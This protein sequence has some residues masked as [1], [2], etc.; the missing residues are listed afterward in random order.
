MGELVLDAQ[1]AS[2]KGGAVHTERQKV[3]ALQEAKRLSLK[4][5]LSDKYGKLD[6]AERLA[7]RA[8]R[9]EEQVRGPWHIEVANRLDHLADLYTAHKKERAA[10][11]LYQR[12]RA[13]RE[14]ALSKHPDIYERD[15]RQVRIRPNQPAEK[16]TEAVPATS[17]K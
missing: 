9:L 12:A 7:Q 3:A 1:N 16:A 2:A 5:E 11:P 13:I 17:Q 4:A 6:E 14:D 10:E 15:G 8:L